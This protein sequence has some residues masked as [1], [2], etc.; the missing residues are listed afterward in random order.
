MKAVHYARVLRRDARLTVMDCEELRQSLEA[1]GYQGP[2]RNRLAALSRT[3]IHIPVLDRGDLPPHLRDSLVIMRG[4]RWTETRGVGP[5]RHGSSPGPHVIREAGEVRTAIGQRLRQVNGRRRCRLVDLDQAMQ[6]VRDTATRGHGY[7]D[8]GSVGL[9]YGYEASK[10][11]VSGR[12]GT[13]GAVLLAFREVDADAPE[14]AF[15]FGPRPDLVIP[16]AIVQ[17]PAQAGPTPDMA[18][19]AVPMNTQRIE[20]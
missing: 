10:T 20:R 14:S 6:V 3:A 18:A 7:V 11:A 15:W 8:G 1:E 19:L 2:L 13:A 9:L 17:A 16:R 5:I 12:L 4:P